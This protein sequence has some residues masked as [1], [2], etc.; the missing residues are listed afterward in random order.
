M[1]LTKRNNIIKDLVTKY[2]KGPDGLFKKSD[3]H[4][5]EVW[6]SVYDRYTSVP[7]LYNK[8]HTEEIPWFGYDVLDLFRLK[9]TDQSDAITIV[10]EV[11]AEE[12]ISRTAARRRGRK[13]WS[14]LESARTWVLNN[15]ATGVYEL[16]WGW[17]WNSPRAYVHASSHPEARAVGLTLNGIFGAPMGQEATSTF[18]EIGEPVATLAHNNKVAQDLMKKAEREL[19][20]AERTLESKKEAIKEAQARSELIMMNAMMQANL[21]NE[22]AA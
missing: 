3:Y 20:D 2:P 7:V 10:R 17:R 13:L 11:Y 22:D 4:M 16:K 18:L 19:R 21:H 12:D 14:R 15:G 6:H 9:I 5:E 8:A 1:D